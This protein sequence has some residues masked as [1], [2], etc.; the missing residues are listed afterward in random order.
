MNKKSGLW[1]LFGWIFLLVFNTV[2]FVAGG[3]SYL[4]S[5]WIAYG[6]IQFSYLMVLA[7][8]VLTRK[9]SSS[10]VFGF[11]IFSISVTYFAAELVVGLLVI[12][13]RPDSYKPSLILQIIMAGI[14][15][16][17][18]FAHLLA[19]KHTADSVERYE[20]EVS[21]I[22]NA[23]SKVK[24]LIGKMGDK[25]VNREIEKAYDV[26]HAS[27]AKS[28]AS[29]RDVEAAITAKTEELQ[30]AVFAQNSQKAQAAAAALIYLVQERN[31]KL[32]QSN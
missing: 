9:S 24:L 7:T 17:V 22:K 13:F 6:F 21:Y 3:A 31:Q 12:L 28:N 16:A 19:N 8:P 32:R 11:S 15:A 2:F 26:L 1:I 29:V 30:S 23:S 4:P 5:T 25:Q 18:L 27:P 10:S 20:A 14:Y